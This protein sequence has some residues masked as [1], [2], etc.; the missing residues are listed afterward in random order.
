MS[1]APLLP[2]NASLSVTAE[3]AMPLSITWPLSAP[4]AS[5]AARLAVPEAAEVGA[6]MSWAGD[7]DTANDGLLSTLTLSGAEVAIMPML[8]MALAVS[9]CVPS[10]TVVLSHSMVYGA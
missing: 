2:A 8:S 6:G 9:V 5:C 1:G 3:R 4:L 7:S 10:L